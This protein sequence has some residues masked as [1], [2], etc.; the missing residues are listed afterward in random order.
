[1]K[2]TKLSFA[3]ACAQYVHRFTMEHVPQW[4]KQVREDGSYYA[5]QYTSDREW[6]D[7]TAFPPQS[8]FP[9]SCETSNQSWP[10]GKALAAP[11]V[12]GQKHKPFFDKNRLMEMA[13]KLLEAL[14]YV[15]NSEYDRREDSRNFE[16]ETLK[17]WESIIAYVEHE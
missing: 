8:P 15:I 11:Y 10:L 2:T 16:P 17:E 7:N 5:P 12:V 6:Y 3:E 4:A 9:D 1:M 13:P 14:Q